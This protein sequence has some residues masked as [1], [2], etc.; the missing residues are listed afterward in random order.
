MIGVPARGRDRDGLGD[1]RA[2]AGTVGVGVG[3]SVSRA[4]DGGLGLRREP[5]IFAAS[6][7]RCCSEPGEVGDAVGSERRR[8]ARR[9]CAAAS[10]RRCQR[11][12]RAARASRRR[13][14]GRL[15]DGAHLEHDVRVDRGDAVRSRRVGSWRRRA[16]SRPSG[17]RASSS[18]PCVVD[19]AEPRGEPGLRELDVETG[20]LKL[21]AERPPARHERRRVAPGAPRAGCSAG[22]AARRASRGRGRRRGTSRRAAASSACRLASVGDGPAPAAGAASRQKQADDPPAPSRAPSS[23]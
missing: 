2:R 23:P 17:C 3:A 8:A 6:S 19:E 10:G 9:S 13:G 11:R 21:V 5:A 7:E 20:E 12:A 14:S 18:V 4:G 16:T 15:C 1:R 22:R